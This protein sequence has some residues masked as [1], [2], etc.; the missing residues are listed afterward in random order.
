MLYSMAGRAENHWRNDASSPGM[1]E[2][3]VAKGLA[4]LPTPD[5][6]G[7]HPRHEAEASSVLTRIPLESQARWACGG[8]RMATPQ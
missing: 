4:G 6:I 8:V 5:G 7:D 2:R 3:V 1:G